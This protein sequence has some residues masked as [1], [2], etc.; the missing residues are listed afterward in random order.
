MNHKA[1]HLVSLKQSI[2]HKR[3]PRWNVRFGCKS[4]NDCRWYAH[5][6]Q[7]HLVLVG[8]PGDI[9]GR[10]FAI[11]KFTRT[12]S[13]GAYSMSFLIQIFF[14]T[15]TF[16]ARTFQSDEVGGALPFIPQI[17]EPLSRKAQV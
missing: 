9:V 8:L 14:D 6:Q 17:I 16:G 5:M 2:L 13:G 7:I 12:N 15:S 11:P 3:N 10:L 4:G 1:M